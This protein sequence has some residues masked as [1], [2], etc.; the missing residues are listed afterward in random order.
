MSSVVAKDE[1]KINM[2]LI[3][4]RNSQAVLNWMLYQTAVEEVDI[5]CE[6]HLDQ[7]QKFLYK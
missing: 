3:F 6:I 5:N 7:A 2:R 4:P 1:Q